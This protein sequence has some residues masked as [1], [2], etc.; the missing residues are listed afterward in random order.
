VRDAL[1]HLVFREDDMVSPHP[2][3]DP[4]VLIAEGL[5]PKVGN[6]HFGQQRSGKD[7]CLLIVSNRDD[8]AGEVL[9]TDLVQCLDLSRIGCHNA[10]QQPRMSLDQVK[11]SI[12]GE[13]LGSI[14]SQFKGEG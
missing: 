12:H 2:S 3:E 14:S 6:P 9:C 4:S 1:A 5:G 10:F 8:S 13:H 11:V 7:A